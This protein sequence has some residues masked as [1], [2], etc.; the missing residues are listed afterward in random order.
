MMI[1]TKKRYFGVNEVNGSRREALTA[2][3]IR[4]LQNEYGGWLIRFVV[5]RK[6]TIF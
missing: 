6:K 5:N 1:I 3:S 4:V 2:R